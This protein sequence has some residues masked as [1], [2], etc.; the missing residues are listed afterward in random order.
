MRRTLGRRGSKSGFTLIEL[1]VVIA[2][3]GV[4]VALIMPAVQAARESANRA[5]CLNN[6][7][8][9]GMAA[10]EYHDNFNSFPAGWYCYP[11]GVDQFGN[12]LPAD[13]NCVST[14]TPFQ[15]Y[16]WSG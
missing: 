7:K 14:A 6:L 15:Q 12:P 9:L 2:I 1:L 10:N 16:M 11:G 4:L 5:K 3:I 13:P 8:Q